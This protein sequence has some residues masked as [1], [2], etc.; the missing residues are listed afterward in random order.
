MLYEV[1]TTGP[2]GESGGDGQRSQ[3]S[4]EHEHDHEE[5]GWRGQARGQSDREADCAQSGD[6]LEEV[7]ASF[8]HPSVEVLIA[9]PVVV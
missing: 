3:P 2:M 1:I 6:D 4:E 7:E 5:P 8:L 9:D